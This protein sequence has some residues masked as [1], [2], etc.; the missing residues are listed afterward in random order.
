MVDGVQP[1]T[2]GG[3]LREPQVRAAMD[4]SPDPVAWGWLALSLRARL[5]L[6]IHREAVPDTDGVRRGAK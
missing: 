2:P 3:S 1:S 4:G 6:R 5:S